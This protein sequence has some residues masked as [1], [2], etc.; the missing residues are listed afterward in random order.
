MIE[1]TSREW[2]DEYFAPGG[3]WELNGGSLQTAL[4][5]K[6]FC[7]HVKLS[8]KEKFSLLDVG[9]AL[10]EAILI[11]AK[12]YPLSQLTGIDISIVAIERCRAML[13]DVARFQQSSINDIAE[14]Y[15]VIY[16][17]NVLEHSTDY[18][19]KARLLIHRC[20]RLFIMVPYKERRDGKPLRPD[21][22]QHHQVTFLRDSFDFLSKEGSASSITV[23]IVSCP[24]A[25]G[26][27][28]RTKYIQ[29]LKN[30][31]RWL[32]GR[33]PMYEQLQIIYDIQSNHADYN[34]TSI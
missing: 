7:A 25:W 3:G 28:R 13:G 15:D 8:E 33:A 19:V 22:A 27:T 18:E 21:S 10:G 4:F 16:I 6:T 24:G 9:C 31:I 14:R 30:P 29:W 23:K 32:I 26:W 17:S 1:L 20:K 34:A 12:N 5:A 11:F 2:W